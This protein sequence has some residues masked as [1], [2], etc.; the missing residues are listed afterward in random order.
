MDI[1]FFY[2][3]RTFTY[4]KYIMKVDPYNALLLQPLKNAYI[5]F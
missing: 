1:E 4:I 2:G 3:L 5:K